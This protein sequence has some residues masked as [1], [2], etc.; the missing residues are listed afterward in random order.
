MLAQSLI[1][2]WH[3]EAGRPFIQ[4]GTYASVLLLIVEVI[5][6]SSWWVYCGLS[7]VIMITWLYGWTIACDASVPQTIGA[8]LAGIGKFGSIESIWHRYAAPFIIISLTVC[9]IM[10]IKQRQPGHC[11]RC[12]YNLRGLPSHRSKCPECG[13]RFRGSDYNP[14]RNAGDRKQSDGVAGESLGR[15]TRIGI[16]GMTR[17]NNELEN[18]IIKYTAEFLGYDVSQLSLESRLSQDLGV[19]GDDGVEF[20]DSY[21]KKFNVR[22][23]FF[24]YGKYFG[25]EGSNPIGC[26]MVAIVKMVRACRGLHEYPVY[27]ISIGD[28]IDAA[29]KGY[30]E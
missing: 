15:G 17:E 1:S 3:M 11:R 20:M 27:D 2:I 28:L 26:L 4:L 23:T 7:L 22:V 16:T 6:R 13:Y 8:L 19:A 10:L 5:H 14:N 18:E 29:S 12:N 9:K 25:A 21:F 30:W 24:D